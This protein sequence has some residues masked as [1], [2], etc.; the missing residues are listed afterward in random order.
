MTPRSTDE[1]RGCDNGRP[2]RWEDY[3]TD[4][5]V[6]GRDEQLRQQTVLARFGELA[7]RSDDLD[8]IL[9]KACQFVGDAL[10][11][12]LAKVVELQKDGKT[13]L[14]RAGIG[15]KPGVV[16]VA[17]IVAS[18]E[19]SE[20][21]ALKTGEPMVSP[22]IAKETRFKYPDFLVEHG[23][24]AVANVIIIGGK[25]RPPFGVLQVDSREPREF[26][27]NDLAFLRTYANLL[28]ATVDR[29]R[30]IEATRAEEA[31]LRGALEEQVAQ[32]TKALGRSNAQLDAFAYTVS[33]DL[34]AP[35][36]AMEGFARILLDDYATEL[37]DKGRGY[38]T[39]IVAA[40]ERME[41]LINDLLAY[42][43]LQRYD[44]SLRLVDMAALALRAAEEAR[45]DEGPMVTIDVDT[46]LPPVLAEPVIL[47]QV[48]SNLVGNAA[49]FRK[50][51]SAGH[52]R[53]W[54]ERNADRV[55]LWVEDDGIGITADHQVGIF[56]VFERLHSQEAYPGTGIG[57]A[58][59]KKG[60][61]CMGGSCGV[62]S[63]LGI[64]S[65]F[66][67]ELETAEHSAEWAERIQARKTQ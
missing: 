36:R 52:V 48:L 7:L 66:W 45:A 10:G 54:A 5:R 61:E 53:V 6:T 26:T 14:V 29:L 40:S 21:H 24:R 20:G 57:L 42:S 44:A 3:L 49:K 1:A 65:R 31:R 11:T 2:F 25:G 33:H 23:V 51:N 35:L 39:R 56:N 55:K 63:A 9:T 62:E 46:P 16:G 37:G 58:I 67:I 50:P 12:D 41:R 22:D 32:R 34:R 60:M 19:T 4:T 15:W 64:G 59:V 28:A 30:T 47:G 18:D 8:E 13:L 27:D 17:T 43:R 38:A